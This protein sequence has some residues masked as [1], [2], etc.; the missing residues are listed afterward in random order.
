[1]EACLRGIAGR[2]YR[3]YF[4]ATSHELHARD[5]AVLQVH[6]GS[7]LALN[8]SKG[9]ADPP[10]ITPGNVRNGAQPYIAHK[11]AWNIH[12]KRQGTGKLSS[13]VSETCETRALTKR[14]ELLGCKAGIKKASQPIT[15]GIPRQRS[16]PGRIRR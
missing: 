2:F 14:V 3:L 8:E 9:V 1:M 12:P 7:F 10:E 16:K 15:R 5:L 4:I 11:A 13:Q 6:R